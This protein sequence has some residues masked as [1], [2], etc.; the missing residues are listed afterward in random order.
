MRMAVIAGTPRIT[1]GG[2]HT[3]IYANTPNTRATSSQV[4]REHECAAPAGVPEST[5]WGRAPF[6][7]ANRWFGSTSSGAV[8]TLA[9]ASVRAD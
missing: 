1:Q 3:L 7:G 8:T 5:S 2:H 9:V 6:L 4:A